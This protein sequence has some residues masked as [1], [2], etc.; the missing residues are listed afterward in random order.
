M[1]TDPERY[2]AAL[3]AA[4]LA[5]RIGCAGTASRA[6]LTLVRGSDLATAVAAIRL[7]RHTAAVTRTN[8]ACSLACVAVLLPLTAAGVLGPSLSAA[9]TAAGAAVLAINSLRPQRS[10]ST[11]G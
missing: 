8:L 9:A 5:D 10:T 11:D 6:A 3:D 7:A 2:G 1:I 4:D